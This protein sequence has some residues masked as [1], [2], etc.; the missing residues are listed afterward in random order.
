MPHYSY[1]LVEGPHDREF[2][3]RL[4]KPIAT[5]R[6]NLLPHL[7]PFWT[8]LVPLTF[9]HKDELN[10]PVPIPLFLT[11]PTH[12]IAIQIAGGDQFGK[13]VEQ[14][15]ILLPHA[16]DSL[17]IILDADSTHTPAERFQAVAEELRAQ[18]LPVAAQPGVVGAGRPATGIFVIPDNSAAGTLESLLLDCGQLEYTSLLGSARNYVQS[19]DPSVLQPDDLIAP[20]PSAISRAP[21]CAIPRRHA[22]TLSS[23]GQPSSGFNGISSLRIAPS[24][25]RRRSLPHARDGRWRDRTNGHRGVAL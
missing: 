19:I 11:S 20:E 3:C 18:G 2:I 13:T 9:P 15:L 25:V 17:G 7:D 4:L 10:K 6:V 14:S 22:R 16:V 24:A 12:Q 1:V 23:A 21:R 8:K 5:Q